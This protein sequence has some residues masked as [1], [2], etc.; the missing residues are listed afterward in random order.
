MKTQNYR[1][2]ILSGDRAEK[3]STVAHALGIPLEDVHASLLPERKEEIV[4][5]LD[6]GDTLYLGDGANDSLA[7]NAAWTT[8]TPVVDR[9]LLEEKADFYFM[10]RS[11][12]FLPQLLALAKRRQWVVRVAFA[13]ARSSW[14]ARRI[15]S[16]WVAY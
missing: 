7:F 8:G 4:R 15:W 2:V 14:A 1:L 12:G 10:G 6:R 9:S 3:V 11:L 13:F 5:D 16:S